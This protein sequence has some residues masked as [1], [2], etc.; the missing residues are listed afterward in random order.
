[1]KKRAVLAVGLCLGIGFG[2]VTSRADNPPVVG[3]GRP[4]STPGGAKKP[5]PKSLEALLKQ[6]R[7]ALA[8]GEYKAA[9]DAFHDVA[10]IDMRNVEALHGQGV[11]YMFLNDFIHALPPM[12]KALV[13]NPSPNRA[14]VLNMAVCQIGQ[15]GSKNAMRAA[16][17]IMDYLSAHP[18]RLDEP[19]LNA[20]AT[21][22]F[23]ADDQAKKGRKFQDCE[24]FYKTYNQKLEAARP[25][26]KRWGVQWQSARS[27]DERTVANAASEKQLTAISRDLDILDG[28]LTEANRTLEKQKDLLRRGFISQ[29]E[30]STNL[31]SIKILTDEQ[32]SRQKEYDAII[33]KIQRP[34]FPKAMTVVAMDDLTPPPIMANA[35]VAEVVPT[36]QLMAPVSVRRT[37][38]VAKP[39]ANGGEK[40]GTPKTEIKTEMPKAEESIIS[41]T[42]QPAAH[43]KVRISSYAAAF[44]ISESLILTAAAPLAG[45]TEIELQMSD[46]TPMKAVLVRVD[47][48]AGLALLRVTDKKMIP[49]VLA[50][51]FAGGAVQCAA[52]PTVN[53]FN[54]MAESI[55]GTARPP[56]GDWRITLS[57]HPRLSGSP[58]L[59]GNKVVGLELA[60][61][62]TD[63]AQVPA[64]TLETI[65]KFLAADLPTP[66]VGGP[67]PCAAMLQLMATRESSG[68]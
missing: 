46:G 38:T 66:P 24:A 40:P 17:I 1:M 26:M 28:K 33:A 68:M 11:A 30:M 3:G 58:L 37:T 27:V 47:E 59:S 53:I 50:T 22:M 4:I 44:P 54:P 10:A 55:P 61:R 34:S 51:A 48:A 18:G 62:E 56:A 64:A 19:L 63:P 6:G 8:A 20:M 14:L 32:E 67:E 7:D 2:L 25:G 52:Y 39:R 57:R 23:V 45:A 13:A 9:C 5:D 42:A 35:E 41:V 21:A 49:L 29:Y 15:P 43:R 16:T 36:V 12:E 60:S 31:Q 65:K